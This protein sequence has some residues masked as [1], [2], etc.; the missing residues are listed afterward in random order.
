MEKITPQN[1]DII[2][3][4]FHNTLYPNPQANYLE[5]IIPRHITRALDFFYESEQKKNLL[6]NVSIV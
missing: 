5:E 3:L 1:K 6:K 4:S 2:V